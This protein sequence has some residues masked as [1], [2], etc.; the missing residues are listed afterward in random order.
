MD[1][2]DTPEEAAFRKLAR[3]WLADNA[4][5]HIL[6]QGEKLSDKEEVRRGRAWQRRLADGGYAGIALP[7]AVGGRGGTTLEAVLFAEE[8]ARYP[9]P[10]G[11][12]IGI[13]QG[14]ALAAI[15]NHG[16]PDQIE[17]FV[18]PTL[19][20]D[21]TWCQLFSE[22]GAGSDLAAVRTRAVRERGEGDWIVDGQKVWSSWAHE[23]DWGLLLARS[24]PKVPKHRGLTF[25]IVDMRTPGIEL[26]PI[27]Q[28]SGA[29]DF[30]ETFMTE[31]RV[32]DTCRLGAVGEGWRVAMTVLGSERLNSGEEE[33]TRS[34]AE[35]IEYARTLPHGDGVALDSSA[36]RLTLA[37]AYAQE[38]AERHFQARMRTFWSRGEDPGALPAIKK[39]SFAGRLQ[40]MSG[41]AMEL[42][43]IAH[44]P[45]DAF[46]GLVDLD[47]LWSVVMRIAGGADEV[48]RNQLA[49]RVLGM[50]PEVRLDKDVPFHEL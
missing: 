26:R 45:D 19:R 17:K 43:G 39:L 21:F 13:G 1:F 30:N 36:V 10:K 27:R 34:A 14:M 50:P 15:L 20:G 22:P 8:E 49:E 4:P 11:P 3:T 2:N 32:P 31:L 48:L 18:A 40:R 12:Y 35:L 47:Y 33:P 42:R 23:A 44:E 25:F 41:A 6:I 37:T 7:K 5:D 16:T 29:S 46:A 38:Q 9:L 28:I 24:D